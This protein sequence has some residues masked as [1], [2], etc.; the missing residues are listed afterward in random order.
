MLQTEFNW[1]TKTKI[2]IYGRHWN[3]DDPKAVVCLVHGL[4]EHVNRYDHMARYFNQSSFSVIGNDHCGHG[5]SGGK[6]GH[7]ERY[8]DFL[9]EVRHLIATAKAHYPSLPIFLYGHSM[10]GN[11]VLNFLLEDEPEIAGTITSGA[12]IQL[13]NPPSNLLYQTG[14]LVSKIAPSVTQSN[15]LDPRHISTDPKEVE[16]YKNDPLVHGKISFGTALGML[17]AADRVSKFSGQLSTPLLAM[18]GEQDQIID[19]KGT[20]ALEARIKSPIEV[21]IWKGLF[22]EIHNEPNQT[23]IFDY[24]INWMNTQMGA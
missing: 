23:T 24:T 22:H 17:E 11:I 8:D 9:M 10:G 13:A 20:I 3:A 21:K 7:A 15:D 14:K 12:W 2:N 19:P 4:G 18:H 1:K 16:A 5:R 6:R